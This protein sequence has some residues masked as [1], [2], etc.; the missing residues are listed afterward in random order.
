[1]KYAEMYTDAD[2]ETHFRDIEV[3][4]SLVDVAP[5]AAPMNISNFRPA[6]EVA[7]I[8]LPSGWGGVGTAMKM[9]SIFPQP[10]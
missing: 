4:L 10:R 6:K 1:M 7:F 2:G 8:T 5:P 3:E 9:A